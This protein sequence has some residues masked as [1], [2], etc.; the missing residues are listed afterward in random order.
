M[1]LQRKKNPHIF[2]PPWTEF[3]YAD[4]KQIS[5]TRWWIQHDLK[6]CNRQSKNE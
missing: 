3:F 1:W 5:H 2:V 6:T 4:L